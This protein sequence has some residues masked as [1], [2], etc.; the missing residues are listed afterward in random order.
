MSVN[1]KMT[2]I[3]DAIRE[4]TGGTAPLTLDGMAAAIEGL[5]VSSAKLETG[6]VTATSTANFSFPHS[7]GVSPSFFLIYTKDNITA[8]YRVMGAY[9]A[10]NPGT[11]GFVARNSSNSGTSSG[12]LTTAGA[13]EEY[14]S[15]RLSGSSK[16][17]GEYLYVAGVF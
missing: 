9:G 16:F 3:A 4:K 5:S 15:M 12:M 17:N 1:S 6:T 11:Y 2:A 7:L 14:I 13:D 8:A 10:A